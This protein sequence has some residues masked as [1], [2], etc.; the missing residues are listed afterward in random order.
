MGLEQTDQ[1]RPT[2]AEPPGSFDADLTF[3]DGMVCTLDMPYH[4][5]GWGTTH[6]EDIM[7]VRANGAFAL[8]SGD[9]RLRRRPA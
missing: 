6:V 4:E 1:P 9:I 7:V 8:S 3:E 5:P 2:G